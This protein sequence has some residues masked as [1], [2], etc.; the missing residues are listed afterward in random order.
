MVKK[1]TVCGQRVLKPFI[2]EVDGSRPTLSDWW[3]ILLGRRPGVFTV[4]ALWR[5]DWRDLMLV[6]F[7]VVLSFSYVIDTK[8]CRDFLGNVS[9]KCMELV[10]VGYFGC[11]YNSIREFNIMPGVF[12]A[13]SID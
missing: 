11:G 13:S 4:S 6:F 5:V 10:G 1:C 3:L 9:G 2:T 8:E 12:N 7:I